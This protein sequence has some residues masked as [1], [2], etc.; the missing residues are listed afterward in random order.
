MSPDLGERLTPSLLLSLN[1]RKVETAQKVVE[2]C[3]QQLTAEL[4]NTTSVIIFIILYF[5]SSQSLHLTSLEWFWSMI[6]KANHF[7]FPLTEVFELHMEELCAK[8]E[9]IEKQDEDC[10]WISVSAPNRF[11]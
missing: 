6:Y 11:K 4:E 5:Y 1:S 9:E 7:L 8:Q 10:W 2:S 3:V